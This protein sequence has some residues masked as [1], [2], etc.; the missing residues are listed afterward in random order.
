MFWVSGA[1]HIARLAS[2]FRISVSDALSRRPD[3]HDA[4]L[5][6]ASGRVAAAGVMRAGAPLI[7]DGMTRHGEKP[8]YSDRSC[9]WRTVRIRYSGA[10]IWSGPSSAID[11]VQISSTSSGIA[12]NASALA[13]TRSESGQ[14]ATFE[15]DPA[16]SPSSAI[17]NASKKFDISLGWFPCS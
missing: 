9:V 12:I 2:P 11:A 7:G 1:P 3:D 4:F 17:L 13:A 14:N 16:N 10:S 5:L 8:S 15:I 6:S